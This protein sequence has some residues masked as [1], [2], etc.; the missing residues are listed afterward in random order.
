MT[1]PMLARIAAIAEAHMPNDYAVTDAEVCG[2]GESETF[3]WP[4]H[5]AGVMIRELGLSDTPP[6]TQLHLL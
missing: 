2:C 1:D 3:H 6:R 4:T 5:F